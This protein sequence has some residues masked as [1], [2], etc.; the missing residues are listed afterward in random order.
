ML[1]Q[2]HTALLDCL[3]RLSQDRDPRP[4]EFG[5]EPAS[6]V[7]A[8]NLERGPGCHFDVPLFPS[9]ARIGRAIEFRI[10]ND[11]QDA[12]LALATVQFDEVGASGHGQVE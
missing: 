12:I 2:G 10:V 3:E 4:G 11:H 9:P 6:C 7:Q 1:D 5:I 8:L